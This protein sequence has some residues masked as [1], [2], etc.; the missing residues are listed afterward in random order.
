MA[1]QV[2]GI[3][4]VILLLTGVLGLVLGE[5]RL[6]G[7][8]NI[9]LMEDVVH[10]VTGG[11]LAY[12]GFGQRDEGVARNV[13][14]GLGAVYLVVGLI[15]FVVPNLFGLLP[16]GYSVVDNVVHL[17]LGAVLLGVGYSAGRRDVSRAR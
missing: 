4:G 8:L 17:G 11:L 16:H 7:V 5:E 6:A 10:L 12:V 3:V 15:G 14:I 9:D 1:R 2:A 13:M